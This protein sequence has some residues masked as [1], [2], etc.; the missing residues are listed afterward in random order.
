MQGIGL[1]ALFELRAR[2]GMPWTCA[3]C[4][5]GHALVSTEARLACPVDIPNLNH[6]RPP[7]CSRN[8]KLQF[9]F[10]TPHSFIPHLSGPRGRICTCTVEGL[11]FVPL[12]WATRGWPAEPKLG[13]K[14][15]AHGRICTDTLRVLSAPSLHW[16]TWAF[17][18]CHQIW[19][20][21][22]DFHPQP[23]RPERSASCSW[24]NAAKKWHSRQDS[25]LQPRRS[26]RRT[27]IF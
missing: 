19:C 18:D 14:V 22:R 27:L 4:P 10:R 3:T 23:L 25:H 2:G 21:V 8:R 1:P 20:R 6:P 11:S 17:G 13:A 9:E 7:S 16:T 12:P 24:A 26:K 5:R 15:G